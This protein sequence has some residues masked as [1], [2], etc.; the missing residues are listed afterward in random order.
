MCMCTRVQTAVARFSISH[1]GTM[2]AYCVGVYLF[3]QFWNIEIFCC[4]F[5]RHSTYPNTHHNN[6]R[7]EMSAVC[8][9]RVHPKWAQYKWVLNSGENLFCKW[10]HRKF[11]FDDGIDFSIR[12]SL[13]F[14]VVCVF[15]PVFPH[16]SVSRLLFTAFFYRCKIHAH[17]AYMMVISVCRML[18]AQLNAVCGLGHF[19]ISAQ[20]HHEKTSIIAAEESTNNDKRAER[21]SKCVILRMRMRE[22]NPKWRQS[23]FNITQYIQTDQIDDCFLFLRWNQPVC[24]R[25]CAWHVTNI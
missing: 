19:F 4:L 2:C 23:I 5:A 12:F 25:M 16:L 3:I 18:I 1:C 10:Y 14:L 9:Y 22:E 7:D 15:S 13:F 6:K 20:S 21:N 24:M 11:V 8:V 17:R